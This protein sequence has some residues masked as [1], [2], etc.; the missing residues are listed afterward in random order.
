[1]NIW[2]QKG[3]YV[4]KKRLDKLNEIR[5]E[6]I[7]E[8]TGRFDY[9]KFLEKEYD[10]NSESRFVKNARDFHTLLRS[11]LISGS[12]RDLYV[13]KYDFDYMQQIFPAS[14]STQSRITDFIFLFS[15]V[16]SSNFEIDWVN[17]LDLL[18]EYNSFNFYF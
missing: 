10:M 9:S 2:K 5:A 3:D 17:N 16:R 15:T 13:T 8:K 12:A 14:G 7:N 1:L 4:F 6:Y 18:S 11:D